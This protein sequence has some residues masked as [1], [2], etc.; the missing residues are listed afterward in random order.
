MKRII[1][2]LLIVT[3]VFSSASTCFAQVQMDESRLV[4]P[5]YESVNVHSESF[6]LG[7]NGKA[8]IDLKVT[9]KAS[10]PPDKVIVDVEVTKLG[11]SAPILDVSKTMQYSNTFH[12]FTYSDSCTLGMIGTYRMTAVYKC[13]RNGKLIEKINGVT[14]LL[15]I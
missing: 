14:K 13:Y 8:M 2:I 4:S 6:I 7:M 15:S 1:S 12:R 3:F 9:P 11:S 5:N 10:N